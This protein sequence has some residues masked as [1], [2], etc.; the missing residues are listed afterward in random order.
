MKRLAFV[1][2]MLLTTITGAKATSSLVCQTQDD[3]AGIALT[4]GSVVGS[5]VLEAELYAGSRIWTS[6]MPKNNIAIAQSF[7]DN[8]KIL[9]D[10]TDNNFEEIIARLR[11]F[12]AHE[13]EDIISAGTLQV[14][15]LGVFSVSCSDS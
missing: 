12:V 10:I 11:L 7:S 5:P 8:D 15:G 3:N 2:I 4:M 13:G 14:Y 9:L 1:L 6:M